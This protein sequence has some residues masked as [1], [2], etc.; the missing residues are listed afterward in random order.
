MNIIYN[1]IYNSIANILIIN[2][3]YYYNI[4]SKYIKIDY[5]KFIIK[6]FLN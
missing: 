4:L 2:N 6:L 1:N 3:E 5:N